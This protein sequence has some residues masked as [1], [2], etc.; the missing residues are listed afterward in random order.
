M[1]FC[2]ANLKELAEAKR[3][4]RKAGIRVIVLKKKEDVEELAAT[5][6]EVL[7]E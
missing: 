5:L 2:N 3:K 4:M 6:E 1:T 7:G